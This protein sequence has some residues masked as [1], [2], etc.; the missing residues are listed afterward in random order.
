VVIPA[1]NEELNLTEAIRSVIAWADVVHVVDS[2]STDATR[3]IAAKFGVH[4]VIQPWLGYA[5]QKNWALEHLPLR[6]DWVF[7]L[8]ADEWPGREAGERYSRGDAADI[9]ETLH[10]HSG[11]VDRHTRA[12][13]GFARRAER[14]CE[15]G[16]AD[17]AL[18]QSDTRK[19]SDR[20][21][22]AGQ[23]IGRIE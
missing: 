12:H 7:I 6:S 4:C 21:P 22:A 16:A 2:R 3:E 8:D 15:Q 9:A 10:H 19:R 23:G 17:A 11:A 13:A 5:K 18:R 20:R 14:S 1:F